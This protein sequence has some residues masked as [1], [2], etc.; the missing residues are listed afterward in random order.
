MTETTLLPPPPVAIAEYTEK[1]LHGIVLTDDYAWLRDKENPEVTTYLEAE[2]AYA[3]ACMAPLPPLR[4][5]LY[6]EML[7]HI[8]QTDTSVPYRTPT[9]SYYS[10]TP[11]TL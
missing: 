3:E 8:K 10:P 4:D 6:E 11:P 1:Q 7:G 2:N 5:H 9:N